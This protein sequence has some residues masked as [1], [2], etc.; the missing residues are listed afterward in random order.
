M[1]RHNGV[2][3]RVLVYYLQH[4]FSIG[5]VP[6]LFCGSGVC[7]ADLLQY[8]VLTSLISVHEAPDEGGLPDLRGVEKTLLIK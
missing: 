7:Q 3:A 2:S 1:R 5:Q 4:I 8:G 6:Y